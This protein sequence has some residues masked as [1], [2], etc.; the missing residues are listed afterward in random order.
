MLVR[1]YCGLV[2]NN[3]GEADVGGATVRDCWATSSVGC[4]WCGNESSV[5]GAAV[6]D[7]WATGSVGCCCCGN[8]SVCLIVEVL[9]VE[10]R[11]V[12][13]RSKVRKSQACARRGDNSKG[14]PKSTPDWVAALMTKEKVKVLILFIQWIMK[15][16]TLDNTQK[17][18]NSK[19]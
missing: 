3:H 17:E 13:C 4:C 2:R 10:F 19:T 12:G 9:K 7:W 14:P 8:G 18:D 6:G 5:G 11:T 15:G 1:N 16:S